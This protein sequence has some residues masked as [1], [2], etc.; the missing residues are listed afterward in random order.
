MHDDGRGSTAA[1]LGLT[2][3]LERIHWVVWCIMYFWYLDH[4]SAGSLGFTTSTSSTLQILGHGG[5]GVLLGNEH[6][7]RVMHND[8]SM[9]HGTTT[10]SIVGHDAGLGHRDRA[11]PSW[12]TSMMEQ[13]Y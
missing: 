9:D 2:G 6:P 1:L 3:S 5:L 12:S 8:P 7:K 10:W 13:Q 4:D 11:S